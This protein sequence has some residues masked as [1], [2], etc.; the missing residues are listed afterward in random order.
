[1]NNDSQELAKY[2]NSQVMG[3][4]FVNKS[5]D[6]YI[7]ASLS[8]PPI[9]IIDKCNSTNRYN[10]I[11]ECPCCGNHVCYGT[12]IFMIRGH[13]Y[14]NSDRCKEKLHHDLGID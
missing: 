14:C 11:V 12:S 9:K 6:E 8:Q 5:T 3:K 7:Y 2:L 4:E 10:Y 1:M 13:I